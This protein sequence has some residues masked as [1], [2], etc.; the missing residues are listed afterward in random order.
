MSISNSS[1]ELA[2]FLLH[3]P[4]NITLTYI[5]SL[6]QNEGIKK[7]D[8]P[9]YITH[10]LCAHCLTNNI[11]VLERVKKYYSCL[12]ACKPLVD[13]D[14]LI[15]LFYG[16]CHLIG[17]LDKQ[18]FIFYKEGERQNMFK[19]DILHILVNS[20]KH[21][22][23][24][25]MQL[26]DILT[27]EA[28]SLMCILFDC[29]LYCVETKQVMQKMFIMLR[30]LLTLSPKQYL[31]NVGS[32]KM[33]ITDFVFLVCVMYSKHSL[34]LTEIKDYILC[35]KDIF[36]YRLKKKNKQKR[37]NILFYIFHV[38]VNKKV[39]NQPIDYEGYSYLDGLIA[40]V[41]KVECKELE[42]RKYT[43]KDTDNECDNKDES[44]LKK[45]TLSVVEKCKYLFFCTE[46]NEQ[47][48][49]QIRYERERLKMLGQMYKTKT[50]NI[51]VDS[52][53]YKDPKNMV[54]VTRL[55]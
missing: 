53:L 6:V 50:K 34:C 4:S 5:E 22:T 51:D 26:E 32:C 42:E 25:I 48:E 33:D 21:T 7:Q 14:R 15:K 44:I 52:L 30:Y 11:W 43:I 17:V 19:N 41:E 24:D 47:L 3:E 31:K 36:Y 20:S 10:F 38:I 23:G 8:M 2:Q 27:E 55:P 49:S 1:N 37:C 12:D 28:F 16:L 13:K 54:D 29:F 9:T 39:I 40:T 18:N 35:L 45:N 46:R